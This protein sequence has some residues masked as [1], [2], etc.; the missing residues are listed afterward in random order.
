MHYVYVDWT[1]DDDP[2]PFYV[3]QGT[4]RRINRRHRNTLHTNIALKHGFLRKIVLETEDREV[5]LLEEIRLIS[6][7]CTFH[8]DNPRGAN[9]TRGGDGGIGHAVCM[10]EEWKQKI[11]ESLKGKA[12][13][14]AVNEKRSLTQKGKKKNRREWTPEEKEAAYASRKGRCLVSEE[15]RKRTSEK[16]K[17]RKR[18]PFSEETK[19]KMSIAAKERCRRAKEES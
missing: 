11:S 5:A 7:L 1:T 15:G 18:A 13:D 4:K 10:T 3:G 19:L 14:P 16:L 12:S 8:G 6:E 9:F 17:G 2:C